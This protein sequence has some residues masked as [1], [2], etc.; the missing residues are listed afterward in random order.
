MEILMLMVTSWVT[1]MVIL[2]GIPKVKL[3]HLVTG[4]VTD[5]VKLMVTDLVIY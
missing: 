2:K 4:M 1:V 3:M 5:L